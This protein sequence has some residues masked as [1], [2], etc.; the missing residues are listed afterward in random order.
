MKG[1]TMQQ[2]IASNRTN[3]SKGTD[4]ISKLINREV[5]SAVPKLNLPFCATTMHN[6]SNTQRTANKKLTSSH[7][8]F[9]N[10]IRILPLHS[11]NVT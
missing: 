8:T 2:T 4:K 9:H 7:S 1:I 11:K 3:K 5:P 10:T 6:N